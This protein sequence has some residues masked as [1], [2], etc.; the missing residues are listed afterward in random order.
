MWWSSMLLHVNAW[1]RFWLLTDKGARHRQTTA[2]SPAATEFCVG[3]SFVKRKVGESELR[4]A[5]PLLPL[6][7][8]YYNAA[9]LN[10]ISKISVIFEYRK[11]FAHLAPHLSYLFQQQFSA[12]LVRRSFVNFALFITQSLIFSCVCLMFI[13]PFQIWAVVRSFASSSAAVKRIVDIRASNE[14][15]P[16]ISSIVAGFFTV[17][18]T[19]SWLS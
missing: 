4:N 13:S 17:T 6:C 5:V 9:F 3:Q 7:L 19:A 1:R 12:V 18:L 10:A 15:S 8:I 2:L 14:R 11:A 16:S